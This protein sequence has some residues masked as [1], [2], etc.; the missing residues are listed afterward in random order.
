M[1]LVMIM[2]ALA[3]AWLLRI[4]PIRTQQTWMGRWQQ[5]LFCFL[6]PPLLLI[7]TAISV[8]SM[9]F[10]GEMLGMQASWLS[11][12]ISISFIVLAGFWLLK[13][14]Y[15]GYQSLQKVKTYQR[16]LILGKTARILEIEF[17]YSA[18]IGF[19]QSELVISQGLVK[20]LDSEHLNAVLAH[21]QAHVYY[22]DTF[23]F[24][25]LG[26]LCHLTAWL[27]NTK[28]LW[29]ELLLLRELRADRKAAEK[30]DPI[31]LAESLLQVVQDT[32]LEASVFCANFS[33][34]IPKTRLEERIDFLLDD[35][36]LISSPSWWNWSW[37]IL[38][39]IPLLTIPFHG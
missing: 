30:I 10:Q 25:W 19:W 20:S 23:W 7:T 4:V 17:P 38:L 3:I 1:H 8:V 22:R 18:Q 14:A 2:L 5:G 6:F 16:Q 32:L 37:V 26:W 29:Q 24:F 34:T 11:Y 12:I 31:L 27:P 13:L 39:F 21:E 33:C 15:Q 9:G 28:A 36:T 35:T